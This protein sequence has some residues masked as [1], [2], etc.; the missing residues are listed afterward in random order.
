MPNILSATL[1][2][3]KSKAMR[4]QTKSILAMG[5]V[6]SV[7]VSTPTWTQQSNSG[8]QGALRAHVEYLADD[9]LEGR[10][11]GSRGHAL[12]AAYVAAQFKQLALAPL[13]D[14][15]STDTNKSSNESD[16]S[17][18]QTVRLL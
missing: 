17:F 16:R 18:L 15:A 2:P 14:S 6:S 11:T 13:G 7:V 5:L 8:I 1:K 9:L 3:H 10:A 12:A 4:W